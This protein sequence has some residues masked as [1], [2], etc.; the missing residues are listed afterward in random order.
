MVHERLES[1]TRNE[2]FVR[3]ESSVAG[4]S[5]TGG[6]EYGRQMVDLAPTMSTQTHIHTHTHTENIHSSINM[7]KWEWG[8][9]D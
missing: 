5:S 4:E 8:I 6:R 7:G 2:G 9:P 1:W 3:L